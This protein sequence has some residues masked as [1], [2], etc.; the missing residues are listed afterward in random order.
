[1]GRIDRLECPLPDDCLNRKDQHEPPEEGQG[2]HQSHPSPIFVQ[3]AYAT[4][5]LGYSVGFARHCYTFLATNVAMLKL[6]RCSAVLEPLKRGAL[7]DF[8]DCSSCCSSALRG[9]S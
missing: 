4:N 1:M 2:F 7:F 6:Q 3:Q 8:W 9:C 5:H